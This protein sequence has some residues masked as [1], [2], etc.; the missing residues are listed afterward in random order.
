M[1]IF[2]DPNQL[3][4]NNNIKYTL[5]YIKELIIKFYTQPII[6]FQF[7]NII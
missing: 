6:C 3:Q 1:F 5:S 7:V 4:A 2:R